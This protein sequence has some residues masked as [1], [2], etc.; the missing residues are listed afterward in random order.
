[1]IIV[2]Q[3]YWPRT[4]NII[5]TPD[6]RNIFYKNPVGIGRRFLKRFKYNN[7]IVFTHAQI[8]FKLKKKNRFKNKF[9][10]ILKVKH[11]HSIVT[12]LSYR[13]FEKK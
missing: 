8:Y 12:R 5:T 1:M 9:Y 2:V 4:L 6:E 3:C 7:I 13:K 10:N 11:Y